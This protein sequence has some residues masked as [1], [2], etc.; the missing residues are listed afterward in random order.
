MEPARRI[1]NE[2]SQNMGERKGIGMS[3]SSRREEEEKDIQPEIREFIS[4]EASN[5]KEKKKSVKRKKETKHTMKRN[6][7]KGSHIRRR[8][9]NS[10][11]QTVASA[12]FILMAVLFLVIGTLACKVKFITVCL[13]AVLEVVLARCLYP[14]PIWIHL[15]V[16]AVEIVAGVFA[17]QALFAILAALVYLVT[18]ILFCYWKRI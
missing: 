7:R 3:E 2:S 15:V 13:M 12:G 17:G 14:L 5:H 8:R 11:E 6:V 16:L 1:I 18:V 9:R 4:R 10:E